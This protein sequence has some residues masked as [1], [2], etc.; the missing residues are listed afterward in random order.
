[1]TSPFAKEPPLTPE[2]AD[3]RARCL[4]NGS[5]RHSKSGNIE[6]ISG[7]WSLRFK[8]H[9][10]AVLSDAED[11]GRELRT[12]CIHAARQRIMAGIKPNDIQAEDVMPDQALVDY[13]RDQA[14]RAAE[15]A[16]WRA[17]NPNHKSIAGLIPIDVEGLLR[18]YGFTRDESVDPNTGEVK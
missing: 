16:K 12:A 4:V 8:N 17:E 18:R 5:E 14:R 6:P 2:V 9:P 3:F 1:M 10:W 7:A 15:A 13:W 11:W